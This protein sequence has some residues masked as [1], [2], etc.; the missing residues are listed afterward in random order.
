MKY[1]K[2][3]LILTAIIT[4]GFLGDAAAQTYAGGKT[5]TQGLQRKVFKKLLRLPY[6]GVFDLINY[7]IDGDTVT[8]SGRV[9]QARNKIDAENA[10]EKIEGVKT[11]VN[12]IE[13]LPLS[14]FDN[15]IRYRLLKTYA[16]RGAGLFRYVQEPNPSVR[17]IVDGGHLTLEGVVANRGDYNLLNIL[18]TGV[19]DIFSVKNNLIIEKEQIR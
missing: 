4:G 15:S 1:I 14:P 17:L 19:S 5:A 10:I 16:A 7:Q 18:A 13:I 6:Y 12:N 9:A 3:F 8:L 11:V 2:S